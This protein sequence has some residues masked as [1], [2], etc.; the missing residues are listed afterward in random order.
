MICG[1]AWAFRISTSKVIKH[2]ELC[3]YV[4]LLYQTGLRQKGA[5]D[6]FSTGSEHPN[7][8]MVLLEVWSGDCCPLNSVNV[9]QS[10][11][12]WLLLKL[13][14][15][16][17]TRC[18]TERSNFRKYYVLDSRSHEPDIPK[19]FPLTPLL[20]YLPAL[21]PAF[22]LVFL[23]HKNNTHPPSPP[24]LETYLHVSPYS[25]PPTPSQPH[26]KDKDPL[27]PYLVAH[28]RRE[29]DRHNER[30]DEREKGE[31]NQRSVIK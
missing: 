14:R 17:T 4:D 24:R 15:L 22:L 16:F 20:T 31:R 5:Q 26:S 25:I 12:Y 6:R 21:H 18:S 27:S 29:T 8:V 2:S 1:T 7:C 13:K 28:N 23:P 10:Q 11:T 30:E 19:K 9:A 3:R